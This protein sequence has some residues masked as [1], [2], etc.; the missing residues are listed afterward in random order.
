MRCP[1]RPTLFVPLNIQTMTRRLYTLHACLFALAL[2]VSV[3][4]AQAQ[5]PWLHV[6]G[7]QIKDPAGNP[8]TLRGVSVLPS[9][10]HNECTTCNNK[11]L[12]EMIAWQADGSRGWYSRVLRLPVTTAKV[13]DPATSFATHIDPYVQQ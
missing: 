1:A 11:P 13:K 10:H 4:S 6:D 2:M 8:V 9:E 3:V 5:K 12:S 7:N